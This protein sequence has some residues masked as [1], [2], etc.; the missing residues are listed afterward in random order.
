MGYFISGTALSNTDNV[1]LAYVKLTDELGRISSTYLSSWGDVIQ[2][3]KT[4]PEGDSNNEYRSYDLLHRLIKLVDQGG[5]VW[6]NSYDMLG[7]RLTAVDPDLGSWSYQ[8][9]AAS[10]LLSQTD[11]RGTSTAM[12]YDQLGRLLTRQVTAPAVADPLLASNVYDE[13]KPGYFNIGR[14]TTS[15]NAAAV[16]RFDYGA[17][18]NVLGSEAI[19]DGQSHVTI[20]GEGSN[21]KTAW[22]RYEP[23]PVEVG[24]ASSRWS[25]NSEGLLSAIPGHIT[26]I[27][28]EADNQTRK[29]AY[30]NGV[31]TE[32]FY[33]PQRRWLTRIT[34]T[35]PNGAKLL[36]NVY[37]R[38]LAGRISRIDGL[39]PADSWV[40]T[41]NS[42]DWLLSADNLGDRSLSE[43]YTYASNGNLLTRSRL[44]GA[45]T[46]PSGSAA[47]A[48]AP[49]KLGTQ[50]LGYDGNGNM[51]A[52]GTRTLSW[53]GANRLAKVVVAGGA[54]LDIAYGAS[55]ARV[56]KSHAF[57]TT[58][59]PSADAEID[60]SG[61]VSGAAAFTRYP[62]MD[63][64]IVGGQKY[65]LHRDH[66]ASVRF[67]TD[68]AGA[69]VET[70]GYAAYG[71]AT[72][73]GFQTQKAYIG[74][75]RDPETGLIYLN[76]RYMD[77]KFG[78]FISPD[79]WDP[80]LPGV[81][82]NRYAYAFNDPINKSDPNG[83]FVGVDDL[84]IGG[85]VVG[86]VM[87]VD[88]YSRCT[89]CQQQLATTGDTI[90]N[91]VND[92]FAS[93]AEK[94]GLSS[95]SVSNDGIYWGAGGSLDGTKGVH[96][97]DKG[98]K[99]QP[100]V[101]IGIGED[102][103][104]DFELSPTGGTKPGKA[105]DIAEEKV[106]NGLKT[107]D[108]LEAI[109]KQADHLLNH[110]ANDS[111]GRKWREEVER[112][113]KSAENKIEKTK[114]ENGKKGDGKD[115]G[116]ENNDSGQKKK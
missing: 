38:D 95:P 54:T 50:T 49:S 110:P 85:L 47:R 19:I 13:P 9:D 7:N 111:K 8:Y 96:V 112:V 20:N 67:V 26:G 35:L 116:K 12:S 115:N 52:D 45:F 6:T 43:T 16:H 87:A 105:Y 32:F 56:K 82:T 4:L 86:A 24:T 10:R 72:N 98:T 74:E 92:A 15:Q 69:L 42:L 57:G 81:G 62:H 70:T 64:K 100:E 77:P 103:D 2:V 101:A 71:E 114:N 37:T 104:G 83:H 89:S 113:K 5:A 3:S 30:A 61:A 22:T 11:A 17:S 88:A 23:H 68:E 109:G 44:T 75:R 51:T 80:T 91:A 76:A 21:H 79:D 59:Y 107:L 108:G 102:L 78:R 84:V 65:W 60:A 34:T 28:Y 46:Y 41:Y 106:R 27:D 97:I 40:Y 48:H 25:Y 29:I 90:S 33:S 31:V 1:P 53:D 66:L 63:L 93:L 55:G 94:L 18:R 99:G 39:T 14:L 36:D 58:L 73:E